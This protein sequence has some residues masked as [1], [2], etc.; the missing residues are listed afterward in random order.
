[1]AASV[2]VDNDRFIHDTID[3]ETVIIDTVAGRL[4]VLVGIGPAIWTR[5]LAGKQ[6]SA[7]V[8]EVDGAYGAPAARAGEDFIGEL[9]SAGLLIES[10]ENQAAA[11]SSAVEQPWP[12][13]YTRPG[14]EHYDD[15]AD[16][17][18]MDPI[19]EVD[20]GLGWPTRGTS[21]TQ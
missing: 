14:M 18:T 1:M 3:G 19:H 20:T 11:V 4:T 9:S 6:P 7:V 13:T 10:N 8:G 15:I 12:A 17:M 2:R 16:I 21:D 5:F